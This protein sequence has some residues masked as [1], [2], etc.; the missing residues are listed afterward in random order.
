MSISIEL[1]AQAQTINVPEGSW[2]GNIGSAGIGFALIF[3]T[4]IMAKRK[5]LLYGEWVQEKIKDWKGDWNSMMSLVFGF[6]GVTAILGSTSVLGDFARWI[7]SVITGLGGIA[8]LA[9][10]GMGAF[11]FIALIMVFEDSNDPIKDMQWGYG[12]AILFPLGGGVFT[13]VSITAGSIL[14]N[15]MGGIPPA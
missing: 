1:A 12:L 4:R 11:C 8:F 13:E 10:I 7:Q 14:V 2:A 15:M 6:F 3:G 9:S 5:S